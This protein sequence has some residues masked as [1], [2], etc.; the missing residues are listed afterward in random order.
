MSRSPHGRHALRSEVV[1]ELSSLGGT[2]YEVAQRLEATGVR[3]KPGSVT[4]CAL[5]VYLGAVVAADPRV[6]AV[7]VSAQR[8]FVKVDDRSWCP[9]IGAP[10][11]KPLR[12]FVA[13]FDRHGYPTLERPL[14]ERSGTHRPLGLSGSSARNA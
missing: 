11:T 4:D 8:V 14:G 3:G 2:E 7:Y 1:H 12:S 10:L 13:R 9:W 6:R 5:A